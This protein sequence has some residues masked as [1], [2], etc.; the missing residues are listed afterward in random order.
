MAE[1]QVRDHGPGI[2]SQVLPRIFE[3]FYRV[4][5]DQSAREGLGLGLYIVR[6]IVNAHGGHIEARSDLGNG[7]TFVVNLPLL[8][9]AASNPT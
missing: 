5:D 4:D 3:R 9:N 8:E 6:E 1:I 2:P 7:A